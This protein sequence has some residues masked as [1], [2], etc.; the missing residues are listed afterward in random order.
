MKKMTG[1][2]NRLLWILVSIVLLVPLYSGKA[3]AQSYTYTVTGNINTQPYVNADSDSI[4][5]SLQGT[6]TVGTSYQPYDLGGGNILLTYTITDYSLYDESDTL[7]YFGS[8]GEITMDLD[9]DWPSNHWDLYGNVL[10]QSWYEGDVIFFN[11]GTP[12]GNYYNL[13]DAM[14][15]R[16]GILD[17]DEHAYFMHL[18]LEFDHADPVPLPGALWLFGSGLAGLIGFRRRLSVK[19]GRGGYGGLSIP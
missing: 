7:L 2:M 18:N 14:L 6:I 9:G 15:L 19:R 10:V 13:P 1:K 3:Q 4:I 17:I 8:N 11:E 5:T 12:S 16:D